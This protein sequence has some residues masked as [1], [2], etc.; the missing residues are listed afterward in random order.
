MIKQTVSILLLSIVATAGFAS[1]SLLSTGQRMICAAAASKTTIPLSCSQVA[2]CVQQN[3]CGS[4]PASTFSNTTANA[5]S[6]CSR[7]LASR[8]SFCQQE[9]NAPK[10]SSDVAA[11]NPMLSQPMVAP[12]QQV[13]RTAAQARSNYSAV[14]TAPQAAPAS[15]T[16]TTN[17]SEKKS[18]SSIRWF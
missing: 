1:S 16:P 6:S 17:K 13:Q 12:T 8:D 3:A 7:A 4:L 11:S 10:D 9:A 15:T 2:A 5:V 18:H 14:E